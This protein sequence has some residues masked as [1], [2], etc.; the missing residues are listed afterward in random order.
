MKRSYVMLLMLLAVGVTAQ[1][2][3]VPNGDFKM[4]EPGTTYRATFGP[5]GDT[6]SNGIGMGV[7][8]NGAGATASSDGGTIFT[9][10]VPNWTMDPAIFDADPQQNGNTG[11]VFTRGYDQLD[12]TSAFNAFGSWGNGRGYLLLSDAVTRSATPVGDQVYELSA[13][14]VGPGGPRVLELLVDGTVLAPTWQV[15]PSYIGANG[16]VQAT[17]DWQKMSRTYASIPDGVV[18]VRIGLQP[19]SVAQTF[20]ARLVMDN[21]SLSTIPEPATM[22]L[23]GLGGLALVRRKRS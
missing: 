2:A 17:A 16:G 9:I 11:D 14:V 7:T 15:D 18:T 5:G 10:D 1:A 13:M 21:I 19:N 20:G 8:L 3:I 12:G 4:Y 6:W 22:L 23:L